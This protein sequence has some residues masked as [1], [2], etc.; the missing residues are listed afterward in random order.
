MDNNLPDLKANETVQEDLSSLDK[1]TQSYLLLKKKICGTNELIKQ[2]NDKLKECER[3]KTDLD[4]TSKEAKKVTCNYNSTLAKVIKLELQNTEY[5]KNIHSLTQQAEEHKVKTAAD[6]Q[7]IQQLICKIKD[8]EK[9]EDSKIMQYDLEK[10]SL[11][12]KIKELEQELKAVK[13]SYDTKIKKIEKKVPVE[14]D[15]KPKLKEAGTNTVLTSDEIQQKPKL[16]EA[17]TNTVLTSDEIQQK[18]KV[19]EKCV[20]THEQYS[21]KDDVY[22]VFCGKC[23]VLLEPPP[24]EKICK[25]M[26]NSCPKLIEKISSPKKV[27]PHPPAPPE[28]NCYEPKNSTLPNT[29]SPLKTQNNHPN[30]IPTNLLSPQVTATP[31]RS[32]YCNNF[33]PVSNNLMNPGAYYI[34]PMPVNAV[35]LPNLNTVNQ[36]SDSMATVASSLSIISSLQKKIDSLETKIEKLNKAKSRQ[37]SDCCQ[38]HPNT[39]MYDMNSSMQFNFMEMWKRMADFYENRNKEREPSD[40]HKRH[41]KKLNNYKVPRLKSKK[42]LQNAHTDRWKV[43]SFSRKV[44][45][46]P[47]RKRPKKR[48]SRY[49]SLFD[50]AD[51]TLNNSEDLENS[52]SDSDTNSYAEVFL[53][54]TNSKTDTSMG[55][56]NSS[57]T[58]MSK[59]PSKSNTSKTPTCSNHSTDIDEVETVET[60]RNSVESNKSVGGETDSG[61]LSDSVESNKLTQLDADIDTCQVRKNIIKVKSSIV[62]R[63]F[64]RNVKSVVKPKLPERPQIKT[65]LH[66]TEFN[67]PKE[68]DTGPKTPT[69]SNECNEKDKNVTKVL[70]DDKTVE[71]AASTSTASTTGRKRKIDELQ[72]QRNFNKRVNL[73]KKIRNIRKCNRT[74]NSVSQNT[75][76]HQ[77]IQNCETEN[78]RTIPEQK[79]LGDDTN[80]VKVEDYTPKKRP[81]IAHV[82]KSTVTD[83]TYSSNNSL[84]VRKSVEK[85]VEDTESELQTI[86]ANSESN[87]NTITDKTKLQDNDINLNKLKKTNNELAEENSDKTEQLKAISLNRVEPATEKSAENN[88]EETTPD[89]TNVPNGLE[90]NSLSNVDLNSC[91]YSNS[92]IESDIN[93]SVKEI[94]KTE[95]ELNS[96]DCLEPVNDS[97]GILESEINKSVQELVET[98]TELENQC[99]S[100]DQV[101]ESTSVPILESKTPVKKERVESEPSQK[102]HNVHENFIEESR[103]ESDFSDNKSNDSMNVSNTSTP[104]NNVVTRNAD[105]VQITEPCSSNNPVLNEKNEDCT[106]NQVKKDITVNTKKPKKPIWLN[107]KGSSKSPYALQKLKQY[108]NENKSPRTYQS[109]YKQILPIRLLTDKYIRRQLQRLM[110]NEWQTSVHWDVIEKLKCACSP[111]IIAKGI[112][113]FLSTETGEQLDKSHTPPAPLM[114]KTQQRIVALLV[115]LGESEPTIFQFVQAGI[116]YKLFRLNQTIMKQTIESLARMYT[117]L[118]RIKKDREKVRIFCC[119]ALYCLGLNAIIVLYTVLTCWPEVFPNN[120][121]SSKLLPRCMAHIITSHQAVGHSKLNAL[122]NLISIFYKYPT[123]T[124]SNDLLNEL[125]TAF[126]TKSHTEVE[127]SLILLAKKEGTTWTYKN[128]IR[129][130]LLPMI[131]N[132]KV[133]SIYRAFWLLGNLMRVFPIED[134]DNSVGQIVEQLC[135]LIN[136]G[137]DEQNEGVISALLSLSRHKFDEVVQNTLKWD[138][139]VPLR[140]R[141]KEQFNGLFNQRNTDFWKNYLRRNRHL[142]ET[143]QESKT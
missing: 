96:S 119:D 103:G 44:E 70:Q 110:D 17:G 26:T 20:M 43:E 128:I 105:I 104:K 111:R 18:P 13:K 64:I 114:T 59:S 3:L 48:K 84:Q 141:T 74:I 8:L 65:A 115:D 71:N 24:L 50:D 75:S 46:S 39:C 6:Q 108:I 73:L 138:P 135:D 9:N 12:V 69:Q 99:K 79:N 54:N 58:E 19:A 28:V 89:I 49:S 23:E 87:Q 140:D 93:D 61:I 77:D 118:A 101:N 72:E 81:R 80:L 35:P 31:S 37:S 30:F 22:P 57:C 113:E 29:S 127:T 131:I 62:N 94:V 124:L 40:T 52:N 126:Q 5:K 63:S 120:E 91:S 122:K 117:I 2:Y 21:V 51:H 98:V 121:T 106:K 123:G 129:G 134:K 41:S 88:S 86:S 68:A 34:G 25:I 42:R 142:F 92:I 112:V 95:P 102:D 4:A 82:P 45:R 16:K 1:L 97:D 136:S 143:R 36:N 137:S 78:S 100:L 15:N 139:A 125:L 38:H 33:V 10:S 60:I 83:H 11:Q 53:D 47:S 27:L 66:L 133:P 90:T 32:E 116:E 85:N 67:K 76:Y 7:H 14:H 107:S 130:A 132:N 109:Q 55:S 56:K